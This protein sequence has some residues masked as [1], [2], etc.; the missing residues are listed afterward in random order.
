MK[1]NTIFLIGV[2]CLTSCGNSSSSRYNSE[3]SSFDRSESSFDEDEGD[4]DDEE[5][6]SQQ[7]VWSPCALSMIG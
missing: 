7:V 5:Q 4:G 2:L 3:S 6:S 1:K